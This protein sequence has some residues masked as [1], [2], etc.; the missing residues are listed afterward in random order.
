VPESP[1]VAKS[2]APGSTV[3]APPAANELRTR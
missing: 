2:D 3:F 1:E